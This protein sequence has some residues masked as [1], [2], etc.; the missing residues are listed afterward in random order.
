MTGPRISDH[1]LLRLLER[2]G[3]LDLEAL[4]EGLQA[5]LARAYEAARAM[6]DADFLI[7][8]DGL[9]F[10]VRGEV[11]VTVLVKDTPRERGR[12]L[13]SMRHGEPQ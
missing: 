3:G 6:G 13:G 10:V 4:R 12:S 1:V 7:R 5:E 9:S 2:S 8:K 11:V